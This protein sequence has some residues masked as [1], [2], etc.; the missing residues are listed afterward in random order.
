MLGTRYQCDIAFTE[1]RGQ[2]AQGNLILFGD[3]VI[4]SL[5][6]V[7]DI[8]KLHGI[9]VPVDHMNI[10]KPVDL[11]TD[12]QE[13]PEIDLFE[14][15]GHDPKPGFDPLA[16]QASVQIDHEIKLF[17]LQ[18]LDQGIQVIFKGMDLINVW[19]FT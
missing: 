19:I 7:T 11:E 14:G 4:E 18:L 6:I 8:E 17:D 3:E 13:F 2:L 1:L 10:R 15:E 9:Q 12:H 16:S 5:P